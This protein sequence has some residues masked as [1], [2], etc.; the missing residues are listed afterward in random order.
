MR[1]LEFNFTGD[2]GCGPEVA[3]WKYRFEKNAL[4][5]E[6][7]GIRYVY[8]LWESLFGCWV[9]DPTT[10]SS[11]EIIPIWRHL[12]Q[13]GIWRDQ[14]DVRFPFSQMHGEPVSSRWRYEANAAFAGFFS[15]IP[16]VMRTL[17]GSFEQFQ[18]LG[19]DLMWNEPRL[20][21]FLDD[22]LF[23]D[24]EQF[25]FSCCALADATERSRTWRREFATALMTEQRA[26][27]LGRLA[28]LP[29]SKATLRTIYKLGPT[30][31]SREVYQG[32]I[33]LVN[34]D[35]TSK[36]LRHAEQIPP[37]VI[38]VLER[39]PQELLQTNIINILLKDLDLTSDVTESTGERLDNFV[40]RL[41][42]YFAVAPPKLKTAMTESLRRV[43]DLEQL[44]A[45][46][47]KW[48]NR[49]IEVIDFPPS[50]V[51]TLD[52]LTP[53]TSAAAMREEARQMQ[54]C[55]S[56]LIPYVLQ[57]KAYFFHWEGSVSAT[58]MLVNT[59][60]E[61]WQLYEALGAGNE[62]VS[63]GTERG[64]CWSFSAR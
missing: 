7:E 56:D 44:F 43:R 64:I 14:Q 1:Q 58:V 9:V 63:E 49:L 59:P 18:W 31:C 25:V 41:A 23:N 5:E 17:V 40:D 2:A 51:Q 62:P 54:S 33:N 50:P 29:C 52:N 10:Q 24:R 22:E 15:G 3:P 53:L 61:G 34:D 19:L 8:G 4:V 27:L 60:D 13:N 38:S 35:P 20:A 28:D 37:E 48:E 42:G 30:P 47:E 21:P 45:Y 57:E 16:K 26:G 39:L 12:N 32:L 46:L 55:L 11:R 6:L 36:V